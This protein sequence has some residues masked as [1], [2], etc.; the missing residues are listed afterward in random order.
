MTTLVNESTQ[1][2]RKKHWCQDCGQRIFIG[3]EYVRQFLAD[4]G[5]TWTFKAHTDCFKASWQVFKFLGFS[6]GEDWEGMISESSNDHYVGA[7]IASFL[8][9]RP[10]Y[11]NVRRRMIISRLA[12]RHSRKEWKKDMKARRAV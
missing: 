7:D 12:W 2:A 3:E 4:Y 1:K 8:R 5:D 10:K 9:A 11:K 6:Y